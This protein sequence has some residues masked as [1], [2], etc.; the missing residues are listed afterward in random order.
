MVDDA[1]GNVKKSLPEFKVQLED[2]EAT[3]GAEIRLECKAEG[4]PAPKVKWYKN[5]IPITPTIG[6]YT[7]TVSDWHVYKS[8]N[9]CF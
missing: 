3:P 1:S 2:K 6:K 8:I 7:I 9:F 5:D 4:F